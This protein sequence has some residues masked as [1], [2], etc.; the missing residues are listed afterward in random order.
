MS[1]SWT[2]RA[3]AAPRRSTRSTSRSTGPAEWRGGIAQGP[4]NYILSKTLPVENGVNRVIIRSTTKAGKV[5]LRA[6]AEG[7]K[8]ASVEIVS[9]P[10]TA[11][12]RPVAG[13]ARRRAALL[14]RAR[15]DAGGPVVRRH[16]PA[17]EGC[18]RG[19]GSERREGGGEL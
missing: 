11:E 18:A 4:D 10:A 9:R 1:R 5:V 2:P 14:P 15:T 7:L 12:G 13:D 8:P 16:A 6:T 17:R 19:G 3:T